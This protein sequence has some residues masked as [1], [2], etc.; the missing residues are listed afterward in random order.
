M[1]KTPKRTGRQKPMTSKINATKATGRRYDCG[2]K[3]K[4]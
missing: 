4:K 2:G 1:A 3:V